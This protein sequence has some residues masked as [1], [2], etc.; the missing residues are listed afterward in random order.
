MDASAQR[1]LHNA[2]R[3]SSGGFDLVLGPV[4]MSLLGLWIDSL[5]DTRPLFTLGLFAFGAVGAVLKVY[6]DYQRGMEAGQ[7]ELAAMRAE[8][9]RL[10]AEAEALSAAAP[11]D[12]TRLIDSEEIVLDPAAETD[13]EE[14]AS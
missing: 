6:Y 10:R 12:F 4:L 5:A 7:A 1:D 14:V 3:R 2:F 8:T 11:A 13:G 9:A